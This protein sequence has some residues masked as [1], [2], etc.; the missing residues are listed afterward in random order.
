[1]ISLIENDRDRYWFRILLSIVYAAD[2]YIRRQLMAF[3]YLGYNICPPSTGGKK[4]PE[5]RGG[6]CL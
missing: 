5:L 3:H 4:K 1:M 2:G 6:S